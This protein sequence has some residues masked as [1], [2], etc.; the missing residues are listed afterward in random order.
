MKNL[1][2]KPAALLVSAALFS[3][4]QAMADSSYGYSAAG[5]GTVTAE[6]NVKVTVT[7]PKLILLRVGDPANIDDLAFTAAGTFTTAPATLSDGNNQGLTTGWDG[8]APTF[9]DTPGQA[10]T[11]Y[12]WTNATGGGNLSCSTN[13]NFTAASNLTAADVKVASAGDLAHPGADTS[14]GTTIPFAQNTLITGTWTYSIPGTKLAEAS[15]GE[16]TQTTTY[17]A[18]SL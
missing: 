9:T 1:T 8:V 17:T 5:T 18:T 10:L 2:L 14:C 12:V 11:A 4:G 15:A 7:V 13:T 16:H 6:A 3:A